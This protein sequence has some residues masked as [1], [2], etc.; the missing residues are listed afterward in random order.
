MANYDNMSFGKAFA[1]ARS[2]LGAGKTFTYKGKSYSTN[3]ADDKKAA[4]APSAAPATSKKPQ[5][6]PNWM[7]TPGGEVRMNTMTPEGRRSDASRVSVNPPPKPVV[8]ATS[9]RPMPKPSMAPATSQRPMPRPTAPKP[10]PAKPASSTAPATSQ[11]PM[12]R[13]AA[14]KPAP[15]K[16]AAM[17]QRPISKTPGAKPAGEGKKLTYESMVYLARNSKPKK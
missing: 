4:S 7:S 10:A 12:P 13:P 1:A 16:P 9:Q 2:Q 8:P 11:R 3:R 17:P 5:A 15:A 14:P 6:R